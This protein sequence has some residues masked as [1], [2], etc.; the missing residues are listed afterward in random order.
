MQRGEGHDG[1]HTYLRIE[2][3]IQEGRELQWTATAFEG[4]D[5]PPDTRKLYD[6]WLGHVHRAAAGRAEPASGWETSPP[7]GRDVARQA[8]EALAILQRLRGE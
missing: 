1:M 2:E 8:G 7:T 5:V 3:L 4:R 6:S